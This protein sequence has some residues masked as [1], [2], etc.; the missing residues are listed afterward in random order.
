MHEFMKASVLEGSQWHFTRGRFLEI[1]TRIHIHELCSYGREGYSIILAMWRGSAQGAAYFPVCTSKVLV[2]A[3]LFEI[4]LADEA[5][6]RVAVMAGEGGFAVDGGAGSAIIGG[7]AF[8]AARG[9]GKDE[10]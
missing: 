7:D 10:G 6:R 1:S 8:G 9:G 4:R 2:A 3:K 5:Y